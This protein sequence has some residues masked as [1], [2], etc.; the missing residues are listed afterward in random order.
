MVLQSISHIHS[1]NR[2]N[3]AKNSG[4]EEILHS[5]CEEL[6]VFVNMATVPGSRQHVQLELGVC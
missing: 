6:H 2:L 4:D 3:A 1:L 5:R